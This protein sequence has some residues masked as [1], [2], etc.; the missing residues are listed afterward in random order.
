MNSPGML[1]ARVIRPPVAGA[2]PTSVDESSIKSI[3]GAKVVQKGGYIAVVAPKEWNAVRAA[4][5]LKVSLAADPTSLTLLN[6]QANADRAA[7]ATYIR[8]LPPVVGPKPPE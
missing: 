2:T 6:Q 1:H 8:S 3:P 5:Q 7:I 4:Q